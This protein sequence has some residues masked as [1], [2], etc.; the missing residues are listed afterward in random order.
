MGLFGL[1]GKDDDAS[2]RE[3]RKRKKR[4]RRRETKPG[5]CVEKSKRGRR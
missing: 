4:R 1:F 2:G 5:S 3:K